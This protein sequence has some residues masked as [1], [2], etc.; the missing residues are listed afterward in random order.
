VTVAV[1]QL[2]PVFSPQDAI[3]SAVQGTQAMLR[4]LGFR[5]DV[6]ADVIDQ[7][8]S[9]AARPATE[10][11]G[12]LKQGDGLIYH[13]SIG[14]K[15]AALVERTP[16]KRVILYHNI[17]PTH[18]YRRTSPSVT[19]WLE[20]GREDV[21]R[22]V[23]IADLCLGYSAFSLEEMAA[24]GAR[25]CVVVPPP[26]DVGRLHPRASAPATPPVVLFVGR[27]APNKRHD[28]LL[29]ALAALRAIAI[30]DARLIFAGNSND[31]DPY[32]RGLRRLAAELGIVD[33]VVIPRRGLDDRAL[34]EL[35]AGASVFACAS[36]HEGFCMPL[37]EA[38]AFSVPVV[39][40]A[41][42]AVPETLGGAGALLH[43]RDP[44]AWAGVLA[45]VITDGELRRT[46]IAAGRRRLEA[47]DDAVVQSRLADALRTIGLEGR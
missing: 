12:A 26:V 1:H 40:H 33:A 18:H 36:E 35:Y 44:L 2:L 19:Y 3:G 30:P 10:L 38:M 8:L 41:A 47:F 22:L 24:G 17:T 11:E 37:V 21:R 16:A 13:L 42:A 31:T 43:Q 20:R 4:K 5:S 29:R 23:P 25:R 45:R 32:A 34:A 7:R 46:M 27:L 15:L 39:A 6:F 28:D 14:S 9:R